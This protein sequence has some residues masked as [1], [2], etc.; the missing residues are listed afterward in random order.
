MA[1]VVAVFARRL[2]V[3]ERLTNPTEGAF[4]QALAPHDL[5]VV[6]EASHTC[7]MTRGVEK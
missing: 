5:A 6:M 3:Q 4:V 1:P 2:W 7:M